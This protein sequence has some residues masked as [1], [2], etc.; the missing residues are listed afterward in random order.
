MYLLEKVQGNKPLTV[1]E[2]KELEKYENEMKKKTTKDIATENTEA[3][4]KLAKVIESIPKNIPK[5][6]KGRKNKKLSVVRNQRSAVNVNL[7]AMLKQ[8]AVEGKT[9]A[10]AELELSEKLIVNSEKS[11]YKN[12]IPTT[13]Y[14]SLN[15]LF[16]ARAE[17]KAAW[18]RG[19]FLKNLAECAASGATIADAEHD[20]DISAGELDKILAAD[21][22]AADV[23]NQ[24][25]RKTLNKL[26]RQ[27]LDKVDEASVPALKIMYS[28]LRKQIV[29]APAD[30][31]HISWQQLAEITGKTRQTLQFDWPNK[32]GLPRNADTT[33][34][35]RI[36]W[37]WFEKFVLDTKAP[38]GKPA[39]Q[40]SLQEMKAKEK[41]LE[42]AE[43]SGNLLRR[44]EVIAGWIAKYQSLKNLH[45]RRVDNLPE[46]IC[47]Q[48]PAAAKEILKN[49]FDEIFREFITVPLS[50]KLNEKA[51]EIFAGLLEMI[52]SNDSD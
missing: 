51:S 37:E 32:Y 43:K 46:I 52:K 8:A 40:N 29:S 25:I 42:L 33:Y 19:R 36:V 23:W 47:N 27:M 34:N 14:Q 15:E 50:L 28:M 48:T 5:K 16:A 38:S 39:E 20:L 30:L 31:T 44:D 26:R 41:A 2:I 9:I 13:K 24:A 11:K 17:L 1:A 21:T 49:S 22:E 3:S 6:H 4:E 10:Q 7:A 18:E 35:L 12:Q 45:Q